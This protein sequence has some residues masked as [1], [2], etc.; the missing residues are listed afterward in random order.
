MSLAGTTRFLRL[1]RRAGGRG[2]SIKL[3]ILRFLT[4]SLAMES[5]IIWMKKESCMPSVLPDA[6][7]HFGQ[8][9]GSFVPE[10]L[11]R[12]LEEL[13]AAYAEARADES[14]QREFE[15]LLRE[16]VGRPTPITFVERLTRHLGGARI[17]LKREDLNSGV[18][19][20]PGRKDANR[21]QALRYKVKQRR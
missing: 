21:L 3:R 11:M 20:A 19:S 15:T 9:G 7:G 5:S 8:Y 17:F 1:M 4:P 10:T 18:E 13:R 2:G 16:Y 6:N 14:F 12:P